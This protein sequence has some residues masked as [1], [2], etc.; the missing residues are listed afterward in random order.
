MPRAFFGNTALSSVSIPA[1]ITA[2]GDRAFSDCTALTSFSVAEE[3]TAY[4][5]KNG[6]LWSKDGTVLVQY[7]IGRADTAFTVDEGAVKIGAGAF[8][9]SS[10]TSLSFPSTLQELGAYSCYA[11]NALTS[12]AFPN[13]SSLTLIGEG[14]FSS[15]ISITEF[16]VPKSVEKIEKFAFYSCKKL[17]KV[18][19]EGGSSLSEVGDYVFELCELLSELHYDG[20]REKWDFIVNTAGNNDH[21]NKLKFVGIASFSVPDGAWVPTEEY[22]GITYAAWA[23]ESDYLAGLAPVK[24]YTDYEITREKF[25][26][27]DDDGATYPEGDFIPGYIHLFADVNATATQQLIVGD[28]Q[29]LVLNLG[30][31][32]LTSKKG[33]RVGG[34]YAY[35]PEASL[36]IKCGTFNLIQGQIQ[37]RYGSTLIFE[38]TIFITTATD[39]MYG[40]QSKLL[41]FVRSEVIVGNGADFRLATNF[42]TEPIEMFISFVDSDVIYT[43]RSSTAIFEMYESTIGD[44][45]WNISFDK[46]SAVFGK[47]TNYVMICESL[48]SIDEN[49]KAVIPF[50]ETQQFS[51][52]AETRFLFGASVPTGYA[53]YPV[54]LETGALMAPVNREGSDEFVNI[55][56]TD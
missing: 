48:T 6:N 50:P 56:V 33:F 15:C 39:V 52:S 8:S 18:V 22:E 45:K 44:C 21:L 43:S 19:F 53:V 36:V 38:D 29:K 55:T 32:T 30:G 14:A 28:A 41:S 37:P 40:V 2:I 35:H 1:S 24:W 23:Q 25:G 9:R 42:K 10:I 20:S 46:D 27:T 3:N 34:N 47:V 31:Y 12:V 51:Y 7:C 4:S 17:N 16:N 13:G 26:A 5:S 54:D 11:S 49:N